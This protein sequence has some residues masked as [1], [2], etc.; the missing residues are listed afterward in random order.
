[1]SALSTEER[2]IEE[3]VD[4]FLLYMNVFLFAYLSE[5][6]FEFLVPRKDFLL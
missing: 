1:M 6:V 4:F 2:L 3:F 5:N